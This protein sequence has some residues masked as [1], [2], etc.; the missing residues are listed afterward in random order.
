MESAIGGTEP[1]EFIKVV[2]DTALAQHRAGHY[3]AAD[4][5]DGQAVW[6]NGAKK[7]ICRL[8]AAGAR[9]V[10][11][12]HGGVAGNVL[13]QVRRDHFDACVA[14]AARFAALNEPNRFPL[15]KRLRIDTR[16]FAENRHNAE[17]QDCY[18]SCRF[19]FNLPSVEYVAKILSRIS[20]YLSSGED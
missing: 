5:A 4:M 9:H 19:H 3:A 1:N 2:L 18:Q 17:K 13:L 8:A 6:A 11:A 10:L 14:G 12:D 16:A 7:I 15:I 20:L